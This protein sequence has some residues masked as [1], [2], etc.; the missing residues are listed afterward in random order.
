MVSEA[1]GQ[2]KEA[3]RGTKPLLNA[4]MPESQAII[5]SVEPFSQ[6]SLEPPTLYHILAGGRQAINMLG[7]GCGFVKR[8]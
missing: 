4:E 7:P 8:N 1:I 2:T 3:S 6:R 5:A